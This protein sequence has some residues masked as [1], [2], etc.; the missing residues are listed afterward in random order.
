MEYFDLR[1]FD[2]YREDNRRE[3]K[4]AKAGLPNSLWETYSS[5]ANCNGGVI[6]LG[7]DENEDG[8][9][10]TTGLKDAAKL[11]KV[12]WDCINNRER[13]FSFLWLTPEQMFGIIIK[14]ANICSF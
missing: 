7:V 13:L 14:T 3:V 12:F 8:S 1:K 6:I 5:M 11:Q 4:R 10:R 9:F 2:E